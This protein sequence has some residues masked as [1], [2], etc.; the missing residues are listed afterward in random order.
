MFLSKIAVS[1]LRGLSATD[2]TLLATDLDTTAPTLYRWI[3]QNQNNGPLTTV[4]ATKKICALFDLDAA[5]IL[6]TDKNQWE[7]I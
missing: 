6:L 5:D 1:A 4:D 2:K 7:I 3:A